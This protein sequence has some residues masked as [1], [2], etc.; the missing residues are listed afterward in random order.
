LA[1]GETTRV[2]L[3]AALSAFIGLVMMQIAAGAG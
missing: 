2:K 1:A 3:D